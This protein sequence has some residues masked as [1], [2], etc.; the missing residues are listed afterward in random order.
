[1]TI[2]GQ[3]KIIDQVDIIIASKE[4]GIIKPTMFCGPSG[5]GKTT[6]AKYLSAKIQSKL[7]CSNCAF[8]KD[9]LAFLKSISKIQNNTVLFLDEVHRLPKVCQ[10]MMYTIID[11]K[12]FIFKE[13]KIEVPPITILAATTDEGKLNKPFLNRFVYKLNL[14][15]YSREDIALIIS[16][17]IR[18]KKK[19]ITAEAALIISD[20][21]R[22]CPRVA[23]ARADWALAFAKKNNISSISEDTAIRVRELLDIDDKGLERK[24]REY[25]DLLVKSNGSLSIKT[26]A[27][28]LQ[29]SEETITETVESFLIKRNLITKNSK[30]RS[31]NYE[32]FQKWKKS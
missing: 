27:Q 18:E 9:E 22:E 19:S 13:R 8:I 12:F 23:I 14:Y 7:V 21:S 16:N 24:D 11:D 10:E 2:V 29:L 30:G 32:E 6:F 4:N 5:Y 3:K 1:M 20:F 28:K 31:L 25:L 17:Y 15:D 26:I